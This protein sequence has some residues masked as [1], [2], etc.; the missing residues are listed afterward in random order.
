MSFSKS[1]ERQYPL[2]AVADLEYSDLPSGD[3]VEAIDLPPGAVVVSGFAQVLVQD[4]G[5]TSVTLDVGDADDDDRY[6]TA[7]DIKG[8]AVGAY[9]AFGSNAIGRHYPEGGAITVKRTEGGTGSSAGKVRVVAEYIVVG[10]AN[11]VQAA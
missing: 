7:L 11:E 6:V 4:N 8:G 5:G 9:E 1:P 10:R 3:D 2:F